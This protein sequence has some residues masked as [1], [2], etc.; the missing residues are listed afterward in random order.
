LPS[1]TG[2]ARIAPEG[3]TSYTLPF[4]EKEDIARI[5]TNLADP[6]QPWS[7]QLATV[8][9]ATLLVVRSKDVFRGFDRSYVLGRV[10]ELSTRLASHDLADQEVRVGGLKLR[11][12]TRRQGDHQTP[13]LT[14][15][16]DLAAVEVAYRMFARQEN[17]FKY[18]CEEY[19][20]DALIDHQIEP[21]D[22]TCE[23]FQIRSGRRPTPSCARHAP[24]SPS[25]SAPHSPRFDNPGTLHG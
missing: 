3:A 25:S 8:T 15:R 10:D 5:A 19:L 1:G 9:G 24:S 22:P 6:E 17:F 21:D 23:R 16:R 2:W 7:R 11:Q 12:I 14:S 13:V 4:T 20:L 18:L